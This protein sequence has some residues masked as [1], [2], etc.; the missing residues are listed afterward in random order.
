V[1][2]NRLANLTP[3]KTAA[4]ISWHSDR[5][6]HGL[7][8]CYES[9]RFEDAQNTTKLGG[10]TL[11]NWTSRY[12]ITQNFTLMLNIDNLFDHSYHVYDLTEPNGIQAVGRRFMI[13]GEARF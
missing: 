1:V 5:Q 11:F 6:S 10:Y 9:G 4:G 7:S 13:G 12:A 3:V 2:G 8:G